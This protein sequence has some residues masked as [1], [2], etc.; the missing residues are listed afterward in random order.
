MSEYLDEPADLLARIRT[1]DHLDRAQFPPLAWAVP[2]LIPEGLGLFTGA[3]K[4]GKSWGAL[5][6]GLAVA[7]GSP[8]LGKVPTGC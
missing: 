6:I 7:A 5:G 2:G 3:P 1:G 8:A 4:T